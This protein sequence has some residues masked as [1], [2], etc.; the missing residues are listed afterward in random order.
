MEMSRLEKGIY[1]CCHKTYLLNFNIKYNIYY[2]TKIQILEPWIH[3]CI[4]FGQ[5]ENCNFQPT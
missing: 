5:E 3:C 1:I 2:K 4:L